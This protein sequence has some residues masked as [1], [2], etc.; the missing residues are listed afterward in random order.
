MWQ[1]AIE[2]S[3]WGKGFAIDKP[4]GVVQ[5]GDQDWD[6]EG[7][8]VVFSEVEHDEDGVD[9]SSLCYHFN[10]IIESSNQ[11]NNVNNI[12]PKLLKNKKV[13]LAFSQMILWAGVGL[14]WGYIGLTVVYNLL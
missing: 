6:N 1:L 7:V 10:I 2:D 5:E 12:S 13:W 14:G 4:F 8:Y 9:S 11:D 3:Y